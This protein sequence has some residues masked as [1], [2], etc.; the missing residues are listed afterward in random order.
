MPRFG[1]DSVFDD[2]CEEQY[3]HL[4]HWEGPGIYYSTVTGWRFSKYQEKLEV[5]KGNAPRQFF[6]NKT[7]VKNAKLTISE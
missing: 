6:K 2:E 3:G 7:A 1:H 4:V 5:S